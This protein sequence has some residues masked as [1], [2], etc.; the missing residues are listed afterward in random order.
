[1]PITEIQ[2][3]EIRK[4]AKEQGLSDRDVNIALSQI[5]QKAINNRVQPSPTVTPA[6]QAGISNQSLTPLQS[7]Q[8]SDQGFVGG[9]FKKLFSSGREDQA[10]GLTGIRR[11]LQKT[12]DLAPA[13]GGTIAGLAGSAI[14]G[15]AGSVVPGAGTVAGG[16]AGGAGGTFVG[17]AAGRAFENAIENLIGTQDQTPIEQV[18][19]QVVDST[20]AAA[21]DYAT[22]G[23]LSKIPGIKGVV[24]KAIGGKVDDWA[25]RSIRPTK[26]QQSTFLKKTGI[27]LKDFVVENGLFKKGVEQVDELIQPLQKSFDDIAKSTDLKVPVQSVVDAFDESISFLRSVPERKIA[28]LADAVE[29]NKN[30]FLKSAGKNTELTADAITTIRKSIDDIIPPSQWGKDPLDQA[31]SVYTRSAYQQALQTASEGVTVGGKNLKELGNELSKLYSFRDIA[32][33]QQYLGTGTLP[34]GLTKTIALAGGAGVVGAGGTAVT[35]GN[36][37]ESIRNGLLFM[38]L[39]SVANSPKVISMIAKNLDNVSGV[40]QNATENQRNKIIK[41]TFRRS[42]TNLGVL[43]LNL[44]GQ[45]DTETPLEIGETVDNRMTNDLVAKGELPQDQAE[46]YNQTGQQQ[47]ED[48][49]QKPF[50]GR[51]KQEVLLM[52]SSM[53]AELKDL[54]EI[55]E[56]YDLVVGEE[57]SQKL[58]LSDTAIKNVNDL[59]GARNDVESLYQNIS[60][61][62]L[63]GPI[64]GNLAKLPYAVES[65]GLQAEIDRVRQVVGKALE[66]GVLR[67]EDEEKYKKI[68][69]TMNDTKEVALNKLRQLHEKLSSDL[70]SYVGLQG[71]YGK[72]RGIENILESE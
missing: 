67:K 18:T 38:G 11:T 40:L 52:A 70:E 4:R 35:G 57:E 1:M 72:G 31:A 41:E 45:D 13:V 33:V 44:L 62:D 32:A 43:N 68:L 58:E 49:T 22:A 37:L 15:A 47:L 23:I 48:K 51:S 19:E 25:L 59:T 69:P 63:V 55:A 54:K 66:G 14:G 8:Q 3:N 36:V 71:E 16:L 53:G 20:T 60:S 46:I 28:N 5:S 34:L 61:S 12:A 42:L 50:G 29:E 10:E 7:T 17:V 39:T 64:K 2:L 24:G 56:V 6:Q 26:P 9:F 21:I 65:K 27:E 30:L